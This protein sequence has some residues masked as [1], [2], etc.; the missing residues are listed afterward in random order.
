MRD[1]LKIPAGILVCIMICALLGGTA[2]ALNTEQSFAF[3][4]AVTQVRSAEEGVYTPEETDSVTVAQ[5]DELVVTLTFERL[6]YNEE[7]YILYAVQDFIEYDPT[8][9]ELMSLDFTPEARGFDFPNEL[10]VSGTVR[11]I[12]IAFY[13]RVAAGDEYPT[14]L[15]VASIT[16]RALKDGAAA[17][18]NTKTQV[19]TYDGMDRYEVAEIKD[20]TVTIGGEEEEPEPETPEPV[21]HTITVANPTG[22]TITASP[23]EAA[24]GE[25][26][27]LGIA[28]ESGYSLTQWLVRDAGNAIV[29]NAATP[30]TGATFTMPDSN[31]TVTASLTYRDPNAGSGTGTGTGTGGGGGGGGSS[32]PVQEISIEDAETPLADRQTARFDDVPVGHWAF[33]FVE[34]LAELGFVNGKTATM[35]YPSDNI[36]RGE[37]VTILARMSGEDITGGATPFTDVDSG[38]YY[39]RA[40]AWAYENG[41]VLGTSATTFSPNERVTR[42]DIAVMIVR[43]ATYRGY[44]FAASVDAIDFTD[45]ADIAEYAAPAVTSM[46]RANV[47]G[48]Y[49][50]GSF[51]PRGNATRAEA[52]KMLA[53]VHNAMFPDLVIE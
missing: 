14:S 11:R 16:F 40:V 18:R 48:G 29:F 3:R 31:V 45:K 46:Q 17:L 24:A 22:G 23:T 35:Y 21:L 38:M 27:T 47:I 30:V 13:S 5:G 28:L 37:F 12:L 51:A 10:E 32:A 49:A 43:Y 2:Q 53:L 7:T 39:A 15:N 19:S 25:P 52:A 8:L 50:D 1:K 42:Q 4:L 33:N 9:L 44:G 41:I 20:V 36:T 26:V 34:Y 6:N